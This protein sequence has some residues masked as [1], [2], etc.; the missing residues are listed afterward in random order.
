[1]FAQVP[2]EYLASKVADHGVRLEK[3]GCYESKEC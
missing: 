3:R 1:M 2:A